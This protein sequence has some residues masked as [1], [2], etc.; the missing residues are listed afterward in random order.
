MGMMHCLDGGNGGDDDSDDGMDGFG[1]TGGIGFSDRSQEEA[2]SQAA[3]KTAAGGLG[4]EGG[5]RT[6]PFTQKWAPN[7]PATRF[8]TKGLTSQELGQKTDAFS[9][10]YG[11]DA[12]GDTVSAQEIGEVENTFN[13]LGAMISV[14]PAIE[15]A[16]NTVAFAVNPALGI[17]TSI[18]QTQA[19]R[20]T[21]AAVEAAVS[22]GLSFGLAPTIS[23]LS[24][25]VGRVGFE[26]AGMA[27][28]LAGVAGTKAA[29]NV[30]IEA[31]A[32]LVS[33]NVDPDAPAGDRAAL[34]GEG[35]L[36]SPEVGGHAQPSF[37]SY[38]SY[39][40]RADPYH[41]YKEILD[42]MNDIRKE[43]R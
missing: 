33:A 24:R 18:A 8:D 32:G 36:L 23:S 20:G 25:S 41:Y 26:T 22:V 16:I 14:N 21:R 27:G 5:G 34:G 11:T 42:S 43:G 19:A 40:Q 4:G 37:S 13:K 1:G 28:A 31:L 6:S 35:S 3:G 30:G 7:N 10:V 17:V 38:S 12:F 9:Q 15:T 2:E 39:A 29:A